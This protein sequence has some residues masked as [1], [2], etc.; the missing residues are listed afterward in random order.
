[1]PRYARTSPGDARFLLGS[2]LA[3]RNTTIGPGT[4]IGA[5]SIIGFADIGQDV[6]CSSRV[7][8]L[9]GRNQHGS[10]E[11]QHDSR[12]ASD[13]IYN[14]VQIGDGSWLGEGSIIT[15]DVGAGCSIGAGAILFKKA[16]EGGTYL[17]NPARRIDVR[18]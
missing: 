3:H 13:L 1:M 7:S 4:I 14:R 9:S 15:E 11:V 2:I 18:R 6:L 8:V 10:A 17:G 16:D 5:F 12:A